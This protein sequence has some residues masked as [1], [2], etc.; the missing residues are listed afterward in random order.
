MEWLLGETLV[1]R[2]ALVLLGV[3]LVFLLAGAL[4]KAV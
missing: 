1:P 2:G 3:A 4:S